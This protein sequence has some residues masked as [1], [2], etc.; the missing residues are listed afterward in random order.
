MNGGDFD[1][2]GLAEYLHLTPQQVL[3]L[4]DRG[5]IPA[6][7][8]AGQWRFSPAE[9]H[10]WLEHRIGLLTDDEE[11]VAMESQLRDH[12]AS[13]QV[14]RIAELMPVEAIQVPLAA[15][16]RNSVVRAM[17]ELA[18]QTGW[19][20][21]PETLREAVL[22]RE[23]MHP[24]ALENGVALLHPRRPMPSILGQAFIAFGRTASGIPFGSESGTLTDCFFLIC[25]IDER[26][27]L[28]IL[29]RLSR[30]LGVPQFLP[31]LR[32]LEQPKDIRSWVAE[33]ES[34]LNS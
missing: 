6:R 24:T 25:S 27:H 1:V 12:R 3:R 15:R 7:K 5:K 11:L 34:C 33:T 13:A 18:S 19:L 16:T 9:I 4:A 28:R 2:D 21:D 22:A 10:L 32:E 17:I 20:W 14:V 29:A 23:E 30:I 8:V 26:S 31:R